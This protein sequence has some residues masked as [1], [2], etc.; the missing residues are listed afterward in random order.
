MAKPHP[1][2]HQVTV[3]VD[4]EL[5]QARVRS[6]GP[7]TDAD[8][9]IVAAAARELRRMAEAD[10]G[11]AERQAAARARMTARRRARE[12]SDG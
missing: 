9:A 10:P 5:V 6:V 2:C 4:G 7:I 3:E 8:L 12:A 11:M 1:T